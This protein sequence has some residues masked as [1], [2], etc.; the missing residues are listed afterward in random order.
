MRRLVVVSGGFAVIKHLVFVRGGPR[1]RG[2]A[3]PLLAEESLL[4]GLAGVVRVF[5][6]AAGATGAVRGSLHVV[7]VPGRALHG[8]VRVVVCARLLGAGMDEVPV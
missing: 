2:V 8:D 4:L 7:T 5:A 3:G 6:G 1:A